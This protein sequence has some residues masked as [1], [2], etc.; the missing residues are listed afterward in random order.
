MSIILLS[1][2]SHCD[3][4]NIFYYFTISH[5][6]WSSPRSWLYLPPWKAASRCAE[7]RVP[8]CIAKGPGDYHHVLGVGRVARNCLGIVDVL[9][10]VVAL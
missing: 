8:M 1:W 6:N 2:L 4:L 3:I 10:V 9:G 5:P 7:L